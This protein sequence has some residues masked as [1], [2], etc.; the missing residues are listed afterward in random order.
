MTTG[1]ATTAIA[2]TSDNAL[3]AL[4]KR[5]KTTEDPIELRRLSDRLERLMF[6][7]QF[8]NAKSG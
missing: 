8:E 4:L 2:E 5:I 6:H 3:L 1:S 7:K